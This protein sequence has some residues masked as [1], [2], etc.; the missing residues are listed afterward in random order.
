LVAGWITISDAKTP[1]GRRRV[2]IRGGLSSTLISI[3]DRQQELDQN[4]YVFAT[5]AGERPSGD[6]IRNRILATAVRRANQNLDR[7]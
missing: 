5:S 6:N 2:K 7:T 4:G 3:R 1:A